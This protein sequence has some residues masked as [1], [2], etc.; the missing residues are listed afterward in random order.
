MQADQVYDIHG[1]RVA[2]RCGGRRLAEAASS[3]LGAYADSSVVP[4]P[5]TSS[6]LR[7]TLK[8]A[9]GEA[10]PERHYPEDYLFR[11]DVVRG[12][13]EP[14]GGLLLTDGYSR[15]TIDPL[16]RAIDG[17]FFPRSL[18]DLHLFSCVYL[19]LALQECLRHHGLYYLHAAA[20]MLRDTLVLLCGNAGSG[21]STLALAL[22]ELPE[23]RFMSDDAVYLQ[24]QASGPPLV[25][26]Y[27]RPI[28]LTRGSLAFFPDLAQMAEG[29]FDRLSGRSWDLDA[30]RAF[31]GRLI[32]Q[33]V[34]KRLCFVAL[35]VRGEADA[36]RPAKTSVRR[37]AG[38]DALQQM[39]PQSG[40]IM[41]GGS[42][43][44]HHLQVLVKTIQTGDNL[45]LDS[46]MDAEGDPR[47]VARCVRDAL[48]FT[49]GQTQVSLG[50]GTQR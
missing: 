47:L 14:G 41:L 2:V 39:L 25:A 50:P 48:G 30:E 13:R 5:A 34:P 10:G 46:G 11:Y 31:G 27:R 18:A 43:T 42:P 40:L 21:K 8:M 12:Y 35:S 16:G 38:A 9:D 29:P 19:N 23:C 26:A 32:D 24:E 22:S 28:H 36:C 45:R 1:V 37:V 15:A 33:V 44:E 6:D 17:R 7:I 3:L 49:P 20:V 4:D